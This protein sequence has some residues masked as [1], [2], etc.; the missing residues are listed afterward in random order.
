M[1]KGESF[2]EDENKTIILYVSKG[3]QKTTESNNLDIHGQIS[4][5]NKKDDVVGTIP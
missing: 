3:K 2:R 4:D 1:K 5:K